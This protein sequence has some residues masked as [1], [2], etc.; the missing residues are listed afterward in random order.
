MIEIRKEEGKNNMKKEAFESEVKKFVES[1]S[2]RSE[3]KKIDIEINITESELKKLVIKDNSGLWIP[4]SYSAATEIS[5]YAK[6]TYN[7]NGLVEVIVLSINFK[8]KE[9]RKEEKKVMNQ[10]QKVLF[11]A[12]DPKYD[13]ENVILPEETKNKINDAIATIGSHDIVYNQW[14]SK[15]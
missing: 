12:E 1:L 10:E 7:K 2:T 4:Q 11:I 3:F 9:E 8:K 13:L 6:E 5:K 15:V 14:N